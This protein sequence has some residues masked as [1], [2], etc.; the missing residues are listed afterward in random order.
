MLRRLRL[1]PLTAPFGLALESRNP[2]MPHY[3]FI[4]RHFDRKRIGR[5]MAHRRALAWEC[6]EQAAVYFAHERGWR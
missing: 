4:M 5:S 2:L 3:C 1:W 6:A